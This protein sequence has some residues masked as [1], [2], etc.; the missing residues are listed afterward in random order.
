MLVSVPIHVTNHAFLTWVFFT[1]L[2]RTIKNSVWA[3][4]GQ[5]DRLEKIITK[6]KR[7]KNLKMPTFCASLTVQIVLIERKA[8]LITVFPKML[9]ITTKKAWNFRR[10]EGKSS[11]SSNIQEIFNGEK[12]IKNKNQTNAFCF[13]FIGFFYTKFTISDLK[14]KYV[15]YPN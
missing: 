13:P 8:S 1:L 5:K 3:G 4:S 9:K 14:S 12:A 11:Y 15:F 6:W 2:W 7:K 10:W